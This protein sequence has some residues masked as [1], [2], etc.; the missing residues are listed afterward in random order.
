MP[1]SAPKEV[2]AAGTRP[3]TP[4]LVQNS[5]A[6]PKII[7]GVS[8]EIKVKYDAGTG[9][10]TAKGVKSTSKIIPAKPT[11]TIT[12]KKA[13]PSKLV[14]KNNW[15]SVNPVKTKTLKTGKNEATVTYDATTNRPIKIEGTIRE[16][17]GST[18]RG[19]NATKVGNIGGEGYDGGHL[20]AH[21]F[22][23]NQPDIGI[24]PQARNL[25]RGAYKKMENEWADWV[26]K[27]YEVEYKTSTY[28]PGSKV[29][30]RFEVEY[31]VKNS[32]GNTVYSNSPTF[33]NKPGQTFDRVNKTDMGDGNG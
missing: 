31:K 25:N 18:K 10:F 3:A 11:I 6:S 8:A 28:P 21:R 16:D 30:E 20:T 17:F 14:T 2:I 33:K 12:Y 23:K 29:P 13:F 19:D 9:T 22:M 26:N 1:P 32:N 4:K 5:A 27:G 7:K 24:S 15:M